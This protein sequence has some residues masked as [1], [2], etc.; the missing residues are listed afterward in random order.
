M[1]EPNEFIVSMRGP[2]PQHATT[3]QGTVVNFSDASANHK[4][5]MPDAQDAL[6][7][8]PTT[9]PL[10]HDEHVRVPLTRLQFSLVFLGLAFAIFLAALDQTIVATALK[11]IIAEFGHQ[12]M[13]AWIGS[14][15]LLTACC[16]SVLYGK[17]ADIFGRKWT[18]I[19]AVSVFELGSLVCGIAQSMEVLIVGRAIA[20]VGGGGIFSMVLI[21]ISDV[22]SFKD[23]GKFQGLI[24]ACFGVSSVIGPLMGGAFSDKVSW[25]WCFYINLPFGALTI[26]TAL[27]YLKFPAPEGS[28]WE[29]LKRVDVYG[30][31]ILFITVICLLVPL[32]LGG[33]TWAWGSGQVIALLIITVLSFAVFVY[34]E[35][36]VAVEPMV[37]AEMF[38]NASVPAFLVV[39]VALGAGF[40]SGSYYISLFFQVVYGAS[41][42]DAGIQSIPMVFGLVLLSIISGLVVS[43]TGKYIPF[44]VIGSL[45]LISGTVAIAYLNEDSSTGIKLLAL[46][47]YGVGAGALIQIRLLGLQAS[48]AYSHIAVAT[49]I[50]T[51]LQT[52]GG[53]I[54]VTITGTIF[55]NAISHETLTFPT[56]VTAITSL[57]SQGIP[58]DATQPLALLHIFSTIDTDESKESMRDLISAF[59]AAFRTSYLWIIPFPVIIL[60]C[61]AWIRPIDPAM[62]NV[63]TSRRARDNAG[64]PNPPHSVQ[65]TQDALLK[66]KELEIQEL[67]R[68]LNEAERVIRELRGGNGNGGST[69][70]RLGTPRYNAVKGVADGILANGTDSPLEVLKSKL[71]AEQVDELTAKVN[72]SKFTIDNLTGQ[73]KKMV[74]VI[75]EMKMRETEL[76]E[77]AK[78]LEMVAFSSSTHGDVNSEIS[79]ELKQMAKLKSR[80]SWLEFKVTGF[81]PNISHCLVAITSKTAQLHESNQSNSALQVKTSTLE[82]SVVHLEEKLVSQIREIKDQEEN[83]TSA[84]QL[85][86]F[87]LMDTIGRLEFENAQLSQSN[88]ELAVHVRKLTES[89]QSAGPD[90]LKNVTR[91]LEKTRAKCQKLQMEADAIQGVNSNLQ[92]QLTDLGMQ[93]DWWRG[94]EYD[95]SNELEAALQRV[96]EMSNEIVRL[97]QANNRIKV[98]F[99]RERR[100][101]RYSAVSSASPECTSAD[102]D[103]AWG[104]GRASVDNARDSTST[105][106]DAPGDK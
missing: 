13:I 48:V 22:V 69:Q 68:L 14:A 100:N 50:S 105:V 27:L 54:G 47:V 41:A 106:H 53:A 79:K 81:L 62:R 36:R 5:F 78:M 40:F 95:K 92:A 15:Y 66:A 55:N 42:M 3:S 77:R 39:A 28:M 102:A 63:D 59:V 29:K 51:S 18:F 91:D 75:A 6:F 44:L 43:K 2:P 57:Q 70:S 23:R 45:V 83:Q 73:V 33:S 94:L 87:D 16:F 71:F 17:F 58:I 86:E 8:V 103:R 21:I 38:I 84:F 56:L 46:F 80:I 4:D 7:S 74:D 30:I 9:P 97:S 72:E 34:V 31:V 89:V 99:D 67:G 93:V 37:P 85:R 101:S 20:G 12:E 90:K 104:K 96:A 25:R 10:D 88:E 98:D 64:T 76:E 24:G 61:V 60:C 1:S 65:E 52:L 19:F 49:A 26:V 35:M 82:S 11:A 32:Q